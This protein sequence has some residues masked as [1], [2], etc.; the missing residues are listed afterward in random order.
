MGHRLRI[1]EIVGRDEVDVGSTLARG[2]EEVPPD[3]PKAIDPH[4][5]AHRV[6]PSVCP[7]VAILSVVEFAKFWLISVAGPHDTELGLLESGSALVGCRIQ[8]PSGI[9]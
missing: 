2:A 7:R 3:A 9:T 5:N 8:T 4:A 6:P 1:A